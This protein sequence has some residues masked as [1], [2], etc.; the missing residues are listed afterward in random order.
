[1]ALSI[2]YQKVF[3]V[4]VAPD[5]ITQSTLSLTSY[6]AITG[7]FI[8]TINI[9]LKTYQFDLRG[10]D[11]AKAA[12]IQAY[13]EANAESLAKGLIDLTN[14]TGEGQF[15]YRDANCLPI[16]FQDGGTLNVGG[17]TNNFTS[18]QVTCLTDKVVASV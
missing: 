5:A 18:F 11:E 17:T 12:E 6:P 15:T 7:D 9:N 2:K 13:C 4:P 8:A 16:S 1:M 10:I 14:P 3:G